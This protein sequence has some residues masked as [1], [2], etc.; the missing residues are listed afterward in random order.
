[1]NAPMRSAKTRSPSK[2]RLKPNPWKPQLRETDEW[3]ETILKRKEEGVQ[4]F[5]P[6]FSCDEIIAV[7]VRQVPGW[8]SGKSG[9]IPAGKK[10]RHSILHWLSNQPVDWI[11]K[12]IA[13][14][15]DRKGHMICRD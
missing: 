14:R 15:R 4:Q 3:R 5:F 2:K 9:M 1:M 12:K 6:L 7:T 13:M 10:S 8:R 11:D